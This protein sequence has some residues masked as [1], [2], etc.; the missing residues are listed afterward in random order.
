LSRWQALSGGCSRSVDVHAALFVCT[1]CH[2]LH[3]RQKGQE[4]PGQ[5]SVAKG[6]RPCLQQISNCLQQQEHAVIVAAEP[7][8]AFAAEQAAHHAGLVA[9]V[10]RESVFA[11]LLADRTDP[12]LLPHQSLVVFRRHSIFEFQLALV[13]MPVI[14]RLLAGAIFG[15]GCITVPP[16]CVDFAF[17]GGVASTPARGDFAF[18]SGVAGALRG[19]H[20]LPVVR[21]LGVSFLAS[22]CVVAHRLGL[23]MLPF[24]AQ[25]DGSAAG[26]SRRRSSQAMRK[27][28]VGAGGLALGCGRKRPCHPRRDD[29]S[30]G[31]DFPTGAAGRVGTDVASVAE[32]STRSIPEAPRAVVENT[33]L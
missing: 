24:R 8:V 1:A 17:S 6:E 3:E 13:G 27:E 18:P 9:M 25:A 7:G 10:D 5:D 2:R 14:S 22:F 21:I 26:A 30:G 32:R 4:R 12:V 33:L 11:G 15:I 16:S 31:F 20:C 23:A 29:Q 28:R 19:K